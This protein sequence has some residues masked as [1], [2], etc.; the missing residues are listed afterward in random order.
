MSL[1]SFAIQISRTVAKA[2]PSL[3]GARWYKTHQSPNIALSSILIICSVNI[4]VLC[5]TVPVILCCSTYWSYNKRYSPLT[6]RLDIFINLQAIVKNCIWQATSRSK[7]HLR[8]DLQHPQPRRK[9]IERSPTKQR[10]K[11]RIFQQR[12]YEVA[13]NQQA[14]RLHK[15]ASKTT[16][17][18][19]KQRTRITGRR[20]NRPTKFMQTCKLKTRTR[21]PQFYNNFMTNWKTCK[22]KRTTSRPTPKIA[23]RNFKR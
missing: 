5:I 23:I 22:E 9:F 6:S 19:E 10:R 16:N 14:T 15:T 20:T 13:I 12:I 21:K 2:P 8:L 11:G 3:H 4:F 17:W 18:V 1:S 7:D